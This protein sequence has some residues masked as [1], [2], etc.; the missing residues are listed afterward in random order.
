[1]LAN[2]QLQQDLVERTLAEQTLRET[3]ARFRN[4]ADTAPVL[5]WMAGPDKLRTFF[6]KTW[7]DFTG[8]A[9]AEQLGEN[10]ISAVHADDRRRCYETYSSSFEARRPF[11]MEYRLRRGDGEYRWVLETGAPRLEPAGAFVGYIGSCIDLTEIKL[12]QER[13]LASQKLESLGML[14][15]G[16]AHDFNNMLGTIF[17]EADLAFTEIPSDSPPRKNLERICAVATRAS[18]VLNLLM[19]YA[20]GEKEE[21]AFEAVDLSSLV[22][23]MLGLLKVSISKK[24]TLETSFG[25]SCP[26]IRANSI[27]LQRVFMNLVTN[28][29]EALGESEGIIRVSTK[30]F[31]K[32]DAT[33]NPETAGSP[34]GDYVLLEVSDTGCGMTRQAFAKAFDPFYTTKSMGRGL[35]LSAVQ[36]IVRSHGGAI[37]VTSTPGQGSTFQVFLPCACAAKAAPELHNTAPQTE[38]GSAGQV[39]LLVEDEET[40]RLVLSLSLQKNGFTVL[41]AADGRAALDLTRDRAQEIS[42]IVLDLNLPEISGTEVFREFRRIRPEAKVVITSAYESERVQNSF[43]ITEQAGCSFVKK[44]YRI[45]EL[46]S[47]LRAVLQQD[48]APARSEMSK[49]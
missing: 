49:T 20:G 28:A 44:P 30:S 9:T 21:T 7:L 18:E 29:S 41:E 27:Q 8:R 24:A 42:A 39:I 34:E 14:A 1:M 36:G 15:A 32:S 48:E 2:Q 10:W 45:A 43:G 4:M 6:N 13:T 46:L 37:H 12:S 5:I 22:E 25:R 16:L 31:R 17:A 38:I 11:Q 26:V 23:D 40:L 33:R 19:A 47:A 35:G 3:E